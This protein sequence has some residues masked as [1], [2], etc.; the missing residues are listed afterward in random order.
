MSNP[1]LIFALHIIGYD[2]WFYISHLLLHT[3]LGWRFHK[4]H[5]EIIH[6]RFMDTYTG[7]PLEGPFQS[8]GYLLPLAFYSFHAPAAIAA[9]LFVNV[10]GLARHDDRT[11]WLIGNHHLLHHQYPR[12]NFG[13]YWLD[14]L[15]GTGS[16]DP[17]K[18]QRGL[19]YA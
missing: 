3:R 18:I 7:H 6:P 9:F 2:I 5:H 12:T 14:W 4:K 19:I 17:A 13:E 1:L 8:L 16:R 11:I 10:R 15:F